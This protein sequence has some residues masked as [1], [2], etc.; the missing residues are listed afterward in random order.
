MSDA[1]ASLKDKNVEF[2]DLKLSDLEGRLRHINFPLSR[3]STAIEQG[4]GFDGSSL[5]GFRD[6]AESDLIVKPDTSKIWID[7]FYEHPTASFFGNIYEPNGQETFAACPRNILRKALALVKKEKIA[8]KILV[9]PEFEFYLFDEASYHVDTLSSGFSIESSE[10]DEGCGVRNAYHIAP[11]FDAFADL[12]S[13]IVRLIEDAGVEVK[14]HHHEVCRFAQ[15]E[16][17]TAFLDL[18][19][20]GDVIQSVKYI[21]RNAAAAEG[22]K[23]TFM[24]KP[25]A[26]EAG[27]GMH[28]HVQLWK[29]EKNMFADSKDDNALSETARMFMGGVIK[30]SR[31]LCAFTNPTTN[32]Y[33]RLQGGMEAPSRVFHS[34]A[35]RK[36]ALRV[37]G[38]LRGGADLR[39]EYRV[40]DA[41][42]NPYLTLA[43]IML[44]GLDGIRRKL[45]PGEL[46][47]DLPKDDDKRFPRLPRSLDEA[48]EAL[49]DDS[50]FLTEEGVF[51]KEVINKWLKTKEKE[52]AEIKSYP[53]PAEYVKY[54]AL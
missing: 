29:G 54:F 44:A 22:I 45:D 23:A 43:G 6:V 33:L 8:D 11:P 24:P 3:L 52:I 28:Y 39:F 35:N 15:M 51:Q 41:A 46:V 10:E 14:Y 38:Y 37:P 49:S 27:S 42:G 4:V 12:R 40:P 13:D 9:L 36:A 20:A 18:Q 7:P 5:G 32:S 1:I 25:L 30:H 21:I 26:G 16:I 31:A 34:R 53:T 2:V 47:V 48:L 19:E 50:S 17:E